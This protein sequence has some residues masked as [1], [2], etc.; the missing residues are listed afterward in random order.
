M[1][2]DKVNKFTPDYNMLDFFKDT[3][4]ILDGK[5]PQ[6][7]SSLNEHD[8][9]EKIKLIYGTTSKCVLDVPSSWESFICSRED[10]FYIV[11]NGMVK[12]FLN[13]T[14]FSE[15]LFTLANRIGWDDINL[16]FEKC[17]YDIKIK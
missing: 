17:G 8:Y 3:I 7:I 9:L 10:Y 4:C 6:H 16:V 11:S 14:Y 5:E 13:K 2:L 1:S 12:S 15:E